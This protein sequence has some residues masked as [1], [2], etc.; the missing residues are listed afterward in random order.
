VVLLLPIIFNKTKKLIKVF[1]NELKFIH[2]SLK[3]NVNLFSF[4][5][6]KKKEKEKNRDRVIPGK[7]WP[8]EM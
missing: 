4:I 8:I 1:G 7:Y 2:A 3:S 5:K 6:K